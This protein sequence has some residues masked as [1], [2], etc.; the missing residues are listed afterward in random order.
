MADTAEYNIEDFTI[1]FRREILFH[2]R[3]LIQEGER[4]TVVFNDGDEI[5]LTVLLDIDEAGDRL[6]FDWGG[7]EIANRKLLTAER[8]FFVAN[9]VG[10]R[11]QF[12]TGRIWETAYNGRP[13]FATRIPERFIRLQ[14]REFFRLE[15]PLTRRI[16]CTFES[17]VDGR[18]QQWAATVVDIGIGGVGMELASATSPFAVGQIIPRVRIDLGRF[19]DVVCDLDVRYVLSVARGAREVRRMGCRF[20]D[21][22]PVG[23]HQLQRFITQIQREERA[24][25]G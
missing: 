18:P 22:G 15:L 8:A 5:L 1:T 11:N 7:S 24:R 25:L 10:V 23:E 6:I 19:D 21:L 3:Q 14:R 13:A 17:V 12:P 20:V 9:P 16:P 2:L 4:L